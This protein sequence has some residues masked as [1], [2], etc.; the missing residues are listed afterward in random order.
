MGLADYLIMPI[1]RV[2]RYGLLLKGIVIRLKGKRVRVKK[3]GATYP[4]ANAY[5]FAGTLVDP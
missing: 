1:Q 5:T 3:V 2:T 4:F